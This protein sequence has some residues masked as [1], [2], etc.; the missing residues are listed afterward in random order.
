M[1]DLRDDIEHRLSNLPD[2]TVAP[3][4]EGHH[5]VCVTYKGKEIAHFQA[6]DVLDIRLTPKF[7]TEQGLSRATDAQHHSERSPKSRWI[8]VPFKTRTDVDRVMQLLDYAC[9]VRA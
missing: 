3:W 8:C 7:I 2:I 9:E 5:L 4:K 1:D 6:R